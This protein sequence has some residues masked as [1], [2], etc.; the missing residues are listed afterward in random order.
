MSAVMF[1]LR[2]KTTVVSRSACDA[3]IA[4]SVKNVVRLMEKK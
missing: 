3:G 2:G 4:Y 1:T